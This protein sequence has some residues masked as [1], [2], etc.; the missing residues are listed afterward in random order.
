MARVCDLGLAEE[1]VLWLGSVQSGKEF[2]HV[3]L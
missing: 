2:Y 3:C 1:I